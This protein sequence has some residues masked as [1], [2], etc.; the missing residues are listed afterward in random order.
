MP[1]TDQCLAGPFRPS[2]PE[3]IRMAWPVIYPPVTV[4]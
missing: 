2:E 3:G 1:S 4:R